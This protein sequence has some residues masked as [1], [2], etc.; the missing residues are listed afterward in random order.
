[1]SSFWFNLLTSHQNYFII[2]LLFY[3]DRMTN[4][5]ETA[6]IA[7]PKVK[8][9]QTL[10]QKDRIL[11]KLW[12]VL[13]I[14]KKITSQNSSLF[15]VILNPHVHLIACYEVIIHLRL[16]PNIHGILDLLFSFIWLDTQEAIFKLLKRIFQVK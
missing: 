13:G 10:R 8:T 15:S 2:D 6:Y 5:G 3:I 14:I 7:E 9:Q 12:K 11:T 1:M 4:L 16:T